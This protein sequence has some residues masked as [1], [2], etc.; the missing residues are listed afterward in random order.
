MRVRLSRGRCEL[1]PDAAGAVVVTPGDGALTV[2]FAPPRNDGG[3][4]ILGCVSFAVPF[5]GGGA[6]RTDPR[7]RLFFVSCF[8]WVVRLVRRPPG[9]SATPPPSTWRQPV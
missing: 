5:S 3:E 6:R 8:G 4:P 7:A 9:E 1:E 2:D